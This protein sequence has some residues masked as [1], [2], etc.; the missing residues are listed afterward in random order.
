MHIWLEN[1][2]EGLIDRFSED[3]TRLD[4]I[5]K[6]ISRIRKQETKDLIWQASI[7]PQA[8]SKGCI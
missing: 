3:A 7:A 4:K 5:Q 2:L 1:R 8:Y 6:H